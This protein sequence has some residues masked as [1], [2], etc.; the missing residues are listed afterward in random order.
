MAGSS[1]RSVVWVEFLAMVL[2]C[3][4]YTSCAGGKQNAQVPVITKSAG[5]HA[6]LGDKTVKL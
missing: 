2:W 1:R 6:V 5:K 3:L 4:I